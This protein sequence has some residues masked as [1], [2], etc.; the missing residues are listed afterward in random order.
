MNVRHDQHVYQ[1]VC[2]QARLP[3]RG[4]R[5]KA[6]DVSAMMG[7]W[8]DIDIK[9]QHHAAEN[10]PTTIAEAQRVIDSVPFPPTMTV[11]SGYGL[12]PYWLF[13][14]PFEIANEDDRRAAQELIVAFQQYLRNTASRYNWTVD[15][16]ADL[17]RILR[18]PG[19]FNI[20]GS[21][22]IL[23][24]FT[25]T[26]NEPR[27][28]PSDFEE[29]LEYETDHSLKLRPAP[30][31]GGH[32]IGADF[33]RIS[34]NCAWVRHCIADAETL[35]E[36]EWY[37]ALAVTARCEGGRDLAHQISQAHPKY[38]A[39][40]TDKKFDQSLLQSRAPRCQY[41][42]THFDPGGGMCGSCV[43][44]GR[45]NSPVK[46]GITTPTISPAHD[47]GTAHDAGRAAGAEPQRLARVL[48]PQEHVPYVAD[49]GSA[50]DVQAVADEITANH[51]FARDGGGKLY[52]YTGG[53]YVA[54]GDAF[55]QRKV[56]QIYVRKARGDKWSKQKASEV[57]EFIRVDAPDLWLQPPR[58]VIN[59]QN[60]LFHATAGKIQPHTPEHLSPIQLPVR[61]DPGAR[62]PMWEEFI[63]DV[64]PGDGEPIAWEIIAWAMTPDTSIQ[65]AALL[66]GEGSNGKSTY[67]RGVVAFL[68]KHNTAAISLHKLEQDR[69]ASARLLG[70]LANICPDLP[71]EHLAGTSTFKALTGGDLFNA[72]HK[73][74]DSFEFI[75]FAKLLFSANLPPKSDDPT[76]GFFRRWVVV[77]FV[78]SF[79]DGAR[80][81]VAR[82]V[83]DAR[84][85]DPQELSGVF[86]KAVLALRQLRRTGR[87]TESE[88]M[89]RAWDEF[90]T[91]TDPLTVW[92]EQNTV[93]GPDVVVPQGELLAAYNAASHQSN[94]GFMTKTAFGLALRRA[95]P[96]LG[97]FQRT[98]NGRLQWCY[99]G[100]GLRHRSAA[101]VANGT[102]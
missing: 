92:L 39:A 29:F 3:E 86:N 41:I 6:T 32:E 26:D 57:C 94:R 43:H 5:G 48:D 60:G 74:S 59:L 24:S 35:P 31:E 25:A 84:L 19:T 90:R 40:E 23:V 101:E 99:V 1:G 100:L 66:L 67:L 22:P 27:Y 2:V 87:F 93:E 7:L 36:P 9:S 45:I 12:Q 49:G 62:C 89:R 75:P 37:R 4:S 95:K 15:S 16:T 63:A 55:I 64:F 71:S 14:E 76:H 78:A 51:H 102:V 91:A 58:D 70:K 11:N 83:M 34:N 50:I 44:Y 17:A 30:V 52:V 13:R 98:V 88:T 61:Y 53:V 82:E 80:N 96:H 65:K 56:K 10:L 8:A 18:L 72:E 28:N 79:E 33:A 81:T 47:V 20:K 68:G 97:S 73:Y 69:F 54:S 21:T 38:T 85:A 77:P 46:L 42:S